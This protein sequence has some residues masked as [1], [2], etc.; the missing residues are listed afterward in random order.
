M[1]L[2]IITI[3]GLLGP[4]P[5]LSASINRLS[6]GVKKDEGVNFFYYKIMVSYV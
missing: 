4:K 3:D 5:Q 1:L 2:E 6:Y